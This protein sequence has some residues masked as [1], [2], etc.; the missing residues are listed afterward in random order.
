VAGWAG[1]NERDR[2]KALAARILE[3]Q[4]Q[5]AASADRLAPLLAGVLELLPWIHQWFR[6]PDADYG[7]PPGEF[8]EAWLDGMMAQLGLTREQLRAWTPPASA[9]G[10]RRRTVQTEA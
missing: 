1:W 7:G 9:R 10:R 5:E 3:L 2:A 8:F 6:E 4:T